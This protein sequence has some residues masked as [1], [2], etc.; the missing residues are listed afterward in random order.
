MRG[1]LPSSLRVTTIAVRF[2][3]AMMASRCRRAELEL[4]RRGIAK[5][6]P[7]LLRYS[8]FITSKWR[9]LI[10]VPRRAASQLKGLLRHV[11]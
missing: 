1:V 10:V 5:R 8:P 7:V 11:L 2:R 9:R 3:R 6:S 4:D